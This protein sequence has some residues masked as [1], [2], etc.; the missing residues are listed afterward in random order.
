MKRITAWSSSLAPFG[1]RNFFSILATPLKQKKAYEQQTLFQF[2]QVL[3][4]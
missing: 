2:V 1:V 4:F 3:S